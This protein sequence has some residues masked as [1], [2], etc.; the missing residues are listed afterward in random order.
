MNKFVKMFKIM[1]VLI[2]PY[3]VFV[4][5]VPFVRTSFDLGS[6]NGFCIDIESRG[7]SIF[8][9]SVLLRSCKP[10]NKSDAEL[11]QMQ[12][13]G[14]G[15]ISI[16]A[17]KRCLEVKPKSGGWTVVFQPCRA[18]LQAQK[19]TLVRKGCMIRSDKL[20]Y[21]LAAG[22]TLTSTGHS[23]SRVL[24]VADCKSVNNKFLS[25]DVHPGTA[26]TQ[27]TCDKPRVG[28]GFPI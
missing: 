19:F 22:S 1:A 13:D 9:D 2:L 8:Y 27:L 23:L 15:P 26:D 6:W 25:W 3:A 14:A 17:H 16:E 18:N 7:S 11:Q 21:C 24:E 28:S 12:F 20:E 5:G 4:E 10:G